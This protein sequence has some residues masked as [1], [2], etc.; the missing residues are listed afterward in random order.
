MKTARI[1]WALL[2]A[3]S[4]AVG[5][6]GAALPLQGPPAGAG[7]KPDKQDHDKDEKGKTEKQKK[8][9]EQKGGF[10]SG[11]K[12]VN[13]AGSQQQGLTATGGTKGV[14]EEGADIGAVKPGPEHRAFVSSMESYTVPAADLKQF[15]EEGKLVPAK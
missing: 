9:P 8:E 13:A 12:R 11:V 2:L 15:Q 6:S 3:M 7:A 10:F 14:G 5:S 4:L 1:S